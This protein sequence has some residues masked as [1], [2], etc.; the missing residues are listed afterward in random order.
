MDNPTK[1]IYYKILDPAREIETKTTSDRTVAQ[2]AFDRSFLVYENE[3]VVAF[4]ATGQTI[5]T[6]L[7]TEWK[8]Q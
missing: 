7:T 1:H 6:T 8:E 3:T 2:V 4:T 5:T